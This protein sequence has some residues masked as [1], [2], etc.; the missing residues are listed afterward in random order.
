[1]PTAPDHVMLPSGVRMEYAASGD[2]AGTPVL[3]I[4][5]W[6]DSWR[7]FERVMPHLPASIRA[8]S[9]SLRGHG[10]TSRPPTGYD[11]RTLATDVA[12]FMT[13]VGVDSAALVGHAMGALVAAR[14]AIDRPERTESLVLMGSRPSFASDPV[15]A[16]LYATVAAMKDPIDP[17]VVREF[18]ESVVVR[19]IDAALIDTAVS[20][21]LKVP[22]RVW[23]AV[24]YGTLQTDF[25]TELRSIAAPT[26]IISGEYDQ[27][28]TPRTQRELLAA[29][30]KARLIEYAG[31]GHA[32]HWESP[33]RCAHD[34]AGFLQ[35]A[36][37]VREPAYA[38]VAG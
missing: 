27:T 3:L 29:I 5:G 16:D 8:Y 37:P 15:L 12:A 22:L 23:R 25:S 33:S 24:M 13:A 26:L 30:P 9:I 2:P 11:V 19:P 31:G 6:S 4:H 17:A 14:F 28:G 10:G 38:A 32:M 34:L 35:Q 20:E 7:S 21:S 1:M 36:Q 18:Q